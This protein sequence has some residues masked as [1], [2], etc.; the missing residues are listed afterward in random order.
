ML[1]YVSDDVKYK[2]VSLKQVQNNHSTF[3]FGEIVR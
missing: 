3:Q 2:L 1:N